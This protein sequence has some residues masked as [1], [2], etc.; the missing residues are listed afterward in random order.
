MQ[1]FNASAVASATVEVAAQANGGTPGLAVD[2]QGDLGL[3]WTY[4]SAAP[5]TWG[6]F[7]NSSSQPESDT[8]PIDIGDPGYGTNITRL[9]A[10]A[11]GDF[12]TAW[13][14]TQ[15]SNYEILTQRLQLNQAPTNSAQHPADHRIGGHGFQ[16]DQ[17]GHL[18]QRR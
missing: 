5:N 16:H 9:A 4:G 6:R 10:D 2:S 1:R 17:P 11:N 15:G 13:E 7:Y 3:T 14:S 12:A 8:F 18:L